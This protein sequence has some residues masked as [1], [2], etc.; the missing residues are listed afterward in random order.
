MK[1]VEGV[2]WS[3]LI[4]DDHHPFWNKRNLWSKDPLLRHLD[5][6]LEICQALEF[7]HEKGIIHRDI[8]PAN[9]MLGAFGEVY[10]LDWG[11]AL[12]FDKQSPLFRAIPSTAQDEE[13]DGFYGTPLYMAPEM[14]EGDEYMGR[15]TDVYLLGA[16]LYEILNGRPPHQGQTVE[17]ALLSVLERKQK[18]YHPTCPPE[19]KHICET[20]M[21]FEASKRYPHVEA[22]RDAI[23]QFMQHRTSLNMSTD[24]Q[25]QLQQLRT[26]MREKDDLTA[27][28]KR[29]MYRTFHS[30]RFGFVQALR[31]WPENDKA[32]QGLEEAIDLMFQHECEQ[33]HI[34]AAEA[35]LDELD[36]PSLQNQRM[37]QEHRQRLTNAKQEQKQLQHLKR[38]LDFTIAGAQRTYLMLVMGCMACIFA[39]VRFWLGQPVDLRSGYKRALLFVGITSMVLLVGLLLGRNTLFQNNAN[40]RF[41]LIVIMCCGTVTVHRAIRAIR[42]VPLNETYLYDLILLGCIV[43]TAAI[44]LRA[45]LAFIAVLLLC[46]AALSRWQPHNTYHIMT[47]CIAA[48]W[49]LCGMFW[50]REGKQQTNSS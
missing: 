20:A 23:V 45:W 34:D 6:L 26:F 46:G 11:L 28:D 35:L 17:D 10:L 30:C 40:R 29:H 27:A 41:I 31:E 19:L 43:L 5:I 36:A 3:E 22:F 9:V 21:A 50:G 18:Y 47:I 2:V 16:T 15:F 37:L 39:G 33:G 1:Y 24:S 4:H 14:L 8:K 48:S 32:Q 49:L 25:L 38:E 44:T 12:I 42:M 13:D 7:A